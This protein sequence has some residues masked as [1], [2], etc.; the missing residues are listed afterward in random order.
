MTV[1]IQAPSVILPT[2]APLSTE[3]E[4]VDDLVVHTSLEFP[5][6][7]LQEKEIHIIATEV[8]VAGVPGA[9]NCWVELS[10]IPSANNLMWPFP[11]P[12]AATYWAAIGGGGGA[13]VPVA[14]LV[15]AATGVTATVH[16]ILIPW[17]IH[18]AWARLVIQ[19]PV[20][21]TPATAFWIVQAVFS[22]ASK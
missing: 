15:E 4:T 12:A 9:L 14:P 7:Y 2:L 20:S 1:L 21:A 10:P 19:T 8:V 18:S 13:M 11:L 17:A 22:G 5:V 6:E 3:T 16:S